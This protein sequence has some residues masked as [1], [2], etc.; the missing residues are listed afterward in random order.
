MRVTHFTQFGPRSCGLYE[1]AK[2]LILAERRLGI[3]ARLVDCD[4]T[5]NCRVGLIDGEIITDS[6]EIAYDSDILVRHSAIPTKYQNI[7]KPIV[8]CLHGRPESTYRLSSSGS[9]IIE[10]VANKARD[11]RYKAFVTFWPEFETAWRSLVSDKLHV[12]NT[13]VDLEYYSGGENKNF[14]GSHK[15]LIADIWR[16][17]VIPLDVIFGVVRYIQRYEPD[18]KIHL[19]GLPTQGKQYEALKPIL[20]G[21]SQ[22]IGSAAGQMKD[23]RNWYKSC[24]CLVTPHTIATRVIRESLAAGLPVIAAPGCKYAGNTADPRNPDMVAIAIKE[25][26]SDKESKQ[27]ALLTA[28]REFNSLITAQQIINVFKEVRSKNTVVSSQKKRKVFIDIGGHLGESVKRFYRQRPDADEF[29]TYCFEPDPAI[30]KKCFDN[31]GAMPNTFVFNSALTTQTGTAQ[32]KTGSINDGEGSTLMSGKLTGGLNNTITVKCKSIKE[33]FQSLWSFDY[34]IVKMNI[35]GGEYELLP[36]LV[37]TG[38]M[39]FID[40]LYV[41]LHSL[42]F[43]LENRIKMDCIELKWRQN[44]TAFKTKI[45]ATTKGMADFGNS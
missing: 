28:E 14:S 3:D 38:L 29:E 5:E 17:D 39:N 25:T 44:M 37:E 13:P 19:V 1:T 24:D 21:L 32:M 4:E 40:E 9:N 22:Y 43:D 20:K 16:D 42:K 11:A 45:F 6:P 36:Y 18:A 7:G 35:E 31:I 26:L 8:M 15:I 33:F 27:Y 30:F 34:C 10:A 41:Q 23:I 2:D 12:V